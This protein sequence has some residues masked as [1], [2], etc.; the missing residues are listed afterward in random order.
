M[1]KRKLALL[2]CIGIVL[3]VMTLLC[4]MPASVLMS[5]MRDV[6]LGEEVFEMHGK[7]RRIIGAGVPP[8]GRTLL[9][10][11][12]DIDSTAGYLRDVDPNPGGF[13]IYTDLRW[14]MGLQR[15]V[16]HGAG[17]NH[18][19]H[20]LKDEEQNVLQMGL[21]LVDQLDAINAGE[22]DQQIQ[23][24]GKWIQAT[25]RPMYL[26]I[27]Y[28]FDGPWNHYE[29]T[30]YVQAYRRIA[31]QLREMN[32]S[33]LVLVWSSSASPCFAKHP[34]EA[35]YPGD[36][37]VD[38]VGISLFRQFHGSLGTEED[39]TRLCEFAKGK[40]LP[41]GIVESTPYGSK[42]G[43]PDSMWNDWFQKTEALIERYDIRMWSY[44]NA[45]WDAQKQWQG[46]G[47]GDCR[48]QSN[49][50]ILTKWKALIAQPRFLGVND[51]LYEVLQFNEIE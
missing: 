39:L 18:A 22:L 48:L 3:C 11:G 38:W 2:L 47:W 40:N 7:Q 34:V 37:Y 4:F 28:E 45:N 12:Q 25:N 31:E 49:P 42:G 41:I 17:V 30:A 51:A 44:I 46:Q 23:K 5:T 10:I 35:W 24:L 33:N 1:S 16:D 50:D 43:I 29:P 14:L 9:V 26:R 15:P 27:G 8:A 32:V 19:Q 36:D 13:M 20:Y 6:V 21:W